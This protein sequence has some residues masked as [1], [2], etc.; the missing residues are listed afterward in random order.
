MKAAI[1]KGIKNVEMQ[2]LPMPDCDDN[3]IVVQNI[4]A[5]I[6]GSDV[7]AY[8]HGGDDNMIWK[9]HEFGHEFSCK[10]IKVGEN[11][12][13]QGIKEGDRLYV[14]GPYAKGDIMRSAT[15]GGFS[16]YIE[17]MNVTNEQTVFK[18]PDEIDDR[19]ASIIEPFTIGCNAAMRCGIESGKKAIIFGAGAIGLTAALTFKYKGCEVVVCDIMESRL[20]LAEELGLKVCNVQKDDYMSKC[21]EILGTVPKFGG[22]SLDCDYYVDAAG[23]QPSVDNL[24]KGAKPDSIICL[25]AMYHK[26]ITVNFTDITLG[27]F[28]IIG[29]GGGGIDI[30]KLSMEII[31]SHMFPVEK[32]ITH[33]FAHE[34]IIEALETACDAQN[35]LKV[36]IKY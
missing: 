5:A 1:Y 17:V 35:A 33:E 11:V 9:N 3:G 6:C 7:A 28:K 14:W 34:N 24:F 10:V 32:I 31:A 20:K 16:E 23:N 36:I 27:G 22:F 4:Y 13:K 8:L 15:V 29:A 12:K 30:I 18:I 25:V 2:E 19:T 21:A 26:P